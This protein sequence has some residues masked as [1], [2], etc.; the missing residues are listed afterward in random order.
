[1]S[2]LANRLPEE[3]QI[4]F[5]KLYLFKDGEFLFERANIVKTL[6]VKVRVIFCRLKRESRY[7]S[8]FLLPKTLQRDV[9][10]LVKNFIVF[11]ERFDLIRVTACC[12]DQHATAK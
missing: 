2:E 10:D 1:M 3:C 12:L 9:F 8:F 7:L 11:D 5:D 6:L 4:L